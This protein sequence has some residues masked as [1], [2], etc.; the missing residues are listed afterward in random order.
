MYPHENLPP[1]RPRKRPAPRVTVEPVPTQIVATPEP[2]QAPAPEKRGYEV[3]YGKPPI[4]TRFKKGQSGNPKGR[5]KGA[6]ALDTVVRDLLEER[7]PVNTPTGPRRVPRIEM[8]LRKLIELGAKGNPRAI[9]QVLRHYATAQAAVAARS[10]GASEAEQ[11]H[12][13][14]D[15][16]SLDLLRELIIAEFIASGET[17]HDPR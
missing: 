10:G 8:L 9:E 1:A 3:G 5:K 11:E 12:S 7:I 4:H 17:C 15:A 14:A 2:M 16:T 6:K 13:A